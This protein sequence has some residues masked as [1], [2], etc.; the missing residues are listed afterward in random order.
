MEKI[1]TILVFKTNIQRRQDVRK[2]KE[3]LDHQNGI[4]DWNV[5]TTDIDCVLRVITD[6]LGPGDILPLIAGC[7]FHCEELA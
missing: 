7:G 4:L 1:A 5:D 2:L 6:D 3:T